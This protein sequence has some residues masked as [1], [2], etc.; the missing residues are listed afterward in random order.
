MALSIR[1]AAAAAATAAGAAAA[2]AMPS[3]ERR[4]AGKAMASI[5]CWVKLLFPL[6]QLFSSY[7]SFLR[8][9]SSLSPGL[10][11]LTASDEHV[12][13]LVA[14][15]PAFQSIEGGGGGGTGGQ[16]ISLSRETEQKFRVTKGN[17]KA[18]NSQFAWKLL[19]DSRGI[20]CKGSSHVHLNIS[21]A[22][23]GVQCKLLAYFLIA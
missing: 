23:C 10:P 1:S 13:Q 12:C 4:K 14:K 22:Y 19:T 17:R 5:I 8:L 15:P 20:T 18:P 2:A 3:D 11:P 9:F 16:P 7:D 21:L 6:P